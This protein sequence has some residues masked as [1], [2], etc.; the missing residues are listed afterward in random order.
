MTLGKKDNW[1]SGCPVD[2]VRERVKALR[3][4]VDATA[5]RLTE[6]VVRRLAWEL[7]QFTLREAQ[8]RR[9]AGEL[10]F[11]DLLVLARAMLR[12]P[13]HGWEVRQRLR[14]RYTRLLLDEFQDTDP[15]QCDL[16]ALIAS[17]EPDARAAPVGRP[18]RRPRAPLRRRRPEA[19]D[20]PLPARRHR[21]VP[22][23]PFGVRHR[24][25]P[26]HAQ[27]PHRAVR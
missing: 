5:P 20:L 14:A 24:A 7:A 25:A 17:G 22:A 26:P 11:H 27:L 23:G 9:R 15:I 3:D 19:V 18:P 2:V 8:A 4:L 1:P 13:E 6:A 16:A 21:R 10:E 12:D